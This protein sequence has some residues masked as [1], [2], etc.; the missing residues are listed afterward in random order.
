MIRISTCYKS[1]EKQK[2]VL[3]FKSLS[4]WLKS[5]LVLINLWQI[6]NKFRTIFFFPKKNPFF[7][8]YSLCRSWWRNN[9]FY[10]DWEL[11]WNVSQ[12]SNQPYL[13]HWKQKERKVKSVFIFS[14]PLLL[15]D[16]NSYY[17]FSRADLEKRFLIRK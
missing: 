13:S 15:F 5:C 6:K 11:I 4:L 14:N 1:P 8:L 16:Y 12:P 9:H 2:N 17:W 7:S 10:N 3:F